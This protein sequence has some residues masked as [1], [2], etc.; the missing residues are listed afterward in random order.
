[1]SIPFTQLASLPTYSS[2]SSSRLQSLYSDISRQKHSN[3]TSFNSNIAWWHATLDAVLANGWQPHS[4]D[5]LIVHANPSLPDSLRYEGTGKPLCLSTVVA[6]LANT[7]I[8]IPHSQF[9]NATQSIYDPGWLPYR[10]ASYV[11][12]KPLRWALQQMNIVGTDDAGH[13]SDA[14]RWRRVKGDYVSVPLVQRATE[15]VIARQRNT[16]IS[17]SDA[18]Y[19]FDSFRAAYAAHALPDVVLSDADLRVLLKHLQRDKRVLVTDKEVIKFIDT[20]APET[21]E[22]TAVDRGILELKTAVANLQSQVDGIHQKIDACTEKASTALRQ[23]RKE[24]ALSYIRSRKHLSDLLTKR[25][26]SLEVLQSTLIRVEASADDIQIMKSYE[27]SATTLR[28]ILSH[29]SLQCDAIDGT[30]DAIASATAD[31][32]EVDDAIRLG[33]DTARTEAGLDVDEDELEAEL[34]ALLQE[35]KEAVEEQIETEKLRQKHERQQ[36]EGLREVQAQEDTGK[37]RI[38]EAA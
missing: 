16:G 3:P 31:A 15:A 11:I 20:D 14:E 30:M 21:P 28:T 34:A 19:S 10:V 1:M 13:E 29:P 35:E 5:K 18:L 33:G 27:S 6:E 2:A 4:P 25:L 38:I 17:L 24:L 9:I 22:I 12:G 36:L 23:K 26:G 37:E 7:R 8:L 32:R